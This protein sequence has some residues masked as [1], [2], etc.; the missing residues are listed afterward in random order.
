M[1]YATQKHSAAFDGEVRKS[2]QESPSATG[3]RNIF[4]S[5]TA[6][7]EG[8]GNIP[9]L[10]LVKQFPATSQI[11]K[12]ENPKD[13]ERTAFVCRACLK[14]AAERFRTVVHVERA[15]NGS[16][17][18]ASDGRRL[19]FAHIGKQI[20]SGDYK[21]VVG[22][23][24]ISFGRPLESCNYP[25]WLKVVP[26]DAEELGVIDLS[27]AAFRKD[28]KQTEKL[29][30]AFNTFIRLTGFPV[31][32]RYIEDLTKKQWTVHGQEGVGKAVLLY[33]KGSDRKVY[34]VIMP[35]L[36]AA[37]QSAVS[38]PQDKAAA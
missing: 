30:I 19:H 16:R 26:A 11:R 17:L 32:L 14:S 18:V 31:N 37:S 2:N 21:P 6:K 33:E 22:K 13:F 35:I 8:K 15:R 34:A 5:G 27:G 10:P 1:K 24:S 9:S 3:W 4:K 36:D 38:I 28:Q 7:P 29:S 25:N 23:D 20:P 12:W